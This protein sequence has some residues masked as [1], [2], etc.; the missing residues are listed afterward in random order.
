VSSAPEEWSITV[1]AIEPAWLIVSQLADP[2]WKAVWI[3]RDEA[4]KSEAQ[5]VPTFRKRG[6]PGGWQRIAIPGKGCWTLRLEYDTSDLVDGLAISALAW[7]SWLVAAI[8]IGWRAWRPPSPPI[9]D[10][11]EA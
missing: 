5:I 8:F 3:G 2:A 6:E 10:E 7:M 1:T 11:P 4:E 9:R